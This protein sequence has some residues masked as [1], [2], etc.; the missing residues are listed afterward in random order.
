M[1][2]GGKTPTEIEAAAARLLRRPEKAAEIMQ[3]MPADERRKV[4][5]A[6]AM[7]E[8]EE[9]FVKADKDKDGKLTYNEF[10]AWAFKAIETGPQRD[11]TQEPTRQQLFYVAIGAVCPFMGFGMVD[12]GLM[13]IF[14]DVLDGTIGCLL[15]CSMLGCAALGN[16]ISN[17]FGMLLHGTI[18]RC[19]EKLGLP[20]PH[21]TN[22]QRKLHSVHNWST[23]GS[24]VGV[25]IG[26]LL[27]MLPL[28]VMDQTAKEE[29]RSHAK[30]HHEEEAKH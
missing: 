3:S 5:L 8:L 26:C 2:H 30:T 14:G 17:V 18:H 29:Q 25:F 15:G 10:R 12:N 4:A 22:Q 24:T 16:A 20:D 21:L 1:A 19:S 9:E 13:V 6:W 23:G 7:T 27:G 11:Q 28:L